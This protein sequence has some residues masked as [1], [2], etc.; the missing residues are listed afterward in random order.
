MEIIEKV[1][2]QKYHV[3]LLEK[4]GDNSVRTLGWREE[5]SQQKRFEKLVQVGNL[6]NSSILDLGCGFG[7]LKPFLD[8][9]FTNIQYIGV[10]NVPEFVE[11][12]K[13]RFENDATVEITQADFAHLQFST[14]D[15]IIASG[16]FSYKLKNQ[17]ANFEVIQ[18]LF[19]KTNKAMAFN[20]LDDRYFKPNNML[21]PYNREEVIDFCKTLTSN[22]KVADGYL[23]DD[24]TVFLYQEKK[25]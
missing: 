17:Q 16:A 15:Y 20:M 23:P 9:H 24:F 22:V 2:L 13:K 4:F 10:E 7:D 6:N 12:A 5:Q 1:I 14:I 19:A 21:V 25:D 18:K 3:H 8:Q 11:V